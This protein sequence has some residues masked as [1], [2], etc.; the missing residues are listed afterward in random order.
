M[1]MIHEQQQE[2]RTKFDKKKK[3]KNQSK[4]TIHNY[5]NWVQYGRSNFQKLWN[6]VN[7]QGNIMLK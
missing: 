7:K 5:M 4:I 6:M 2:K 3:K 1:N